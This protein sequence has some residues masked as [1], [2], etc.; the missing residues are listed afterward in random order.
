[1]KKVG[2]ITSIELNAGLSTSINLA[3]DINHAHHSSVL[4]SVKKQKLE[5]YKQILASL[6]TVKSSLDG[7][8]RLQ[9]KINETSSVLLHKTLIVNQLVLTYSEKIVRSNDLKSSEEVISHILDKCYLSSTKTIPFHE[10][11][12]TLNNLDL[13]QDEIENG[14][15][16]EEYVE[17]IRK[18]EEKLILELSKRIET[19]MFDLENITSYSLIRFSLDLIYRKDI[20][21]Y[22]HVIRSIVKVRKRQAF[23]NISKL[24]TN[25]LCYY[26]SQLT[27]IIKLEKEKMLQILGDDSFN[28]VSEIFSQYLAILP[29][30]LKQE[31]KSFNFFELFSC[32]Q[33]IESIKPS[34]NHLEKLETVLRDQINSYSVYS[35]HNI[36]SLSDI[37]D[38]NA[39][40]Y[41]KYKI[42]ELF[43]TRQNLRNQ[44]TIN[45]YYQVCFEIIDRIIGY[46]F[47]L[48]SAKGL[49]ISLNIHELVLSTFED[50]PSHISQTIEELKKK[51]IKHEVKQIMAN[52]LRPSSD[53]SHSFVN[54]YYKVLH[55]N[56]LSPEIQEISSS[57]I[58]I[59]ISKEISHKIIKKV[60]EKVSISRSNLLLSPNLLHILLK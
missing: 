4:K 60:T 26:I 12:E 52:L 59:S 58:R 48:N 10:I 30:L 40:Y 36:S 16:H 22:E 42:A 15:V 9:Q 25:D 3:Y 45:Y 19:I 6:K 46:F 29:I 7:C 56:I 43:I 8:Q 44:Q 37:N 11:I 54:F 55:N 13:I 2:N 38:F 18:I 41:I 27:Q 50:Y 24:K 34:L 49:V 35:T 23:I 1:M 20:R 57:S 21:K 51:L 39:L 32:L 53:F 33:C 5:N 47:D 17:N 14:S 31:V 28:I